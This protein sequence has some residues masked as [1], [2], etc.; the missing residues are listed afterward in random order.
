MHS[1]V[2]DRDKAAAFEKMNYPHR[3]TA[4]LAAGLPL[5]VHG[6][7]QDA[8]EALVKKHGIGIVFSDYDDLAEK[9]YDSQLV[10]S[11]T[12]TAYISRKKFS[13]DSNAGNL[14]SIL[15]TYARR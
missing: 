13:F 14:V 9:L 6:E 7:G 8:M 3:Y 15:E 10:T 11:L 1:K 12:S 2:D 5:V 4:Y